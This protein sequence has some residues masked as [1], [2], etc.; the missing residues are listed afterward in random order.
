MVLVL[1]LNYNKLLQMSLI[2][3]L[4]GTTKMFVCFSKNFLMGESREHLVAATV[5]INWRIV[6][7]FYSSSQIRS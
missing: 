4:V 2:V 3:V 1:P 5:D 6:D 7:F